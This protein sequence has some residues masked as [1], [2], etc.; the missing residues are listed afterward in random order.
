MGYLTGDEGL[1][2]DL[3]LAQE[4]LEIAFASGFLD[5]INAATGERYAPEPVLARLA[6]EPKRVLELEL[7]GG[8]LYR[9]VE[10]IIDRVLCLRE[11]N[12]PTVIIDHEIER[13]NEAVN[14]LVH[15]RER[16]ERL[17]SLDGRSFDAL[18]LRVR[19]VLDGS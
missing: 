10:V 9:R 12:A 8:D 17:A 14:T 2:V 18:E 13:L 3:R 16:A 11:C 5:A 7:D 4:H 19:R 6:G 15:N 1:P